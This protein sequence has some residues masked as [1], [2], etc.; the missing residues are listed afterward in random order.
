[1]PTPPKVPVEERLFSLVLALLATEHG[2]TKADILGTVQGYRQRYVHSGDNASLERQFER[3]KDDIRELGVPLETIGEPGQNDNQQLRY[4]IPKAAYEL[5]ADVHFTPEELTLLGLAAQ[6]WREGSLS[7][8][9]RRAILKLGAHEHELDPVLGLAPRLNTRERAFEPLS[10]ALERHV[11]VT[12]PYLKPGAAEARVRRVRPL[13]L[14]QHDG[15]WYLGAHDE[16]AGGDRTFLLSRIS[17]EVTVTAQSFPADDSDHA[18]ATLDDLQRL[19]EQNLALVAVEPGSDAELRLR[20]RA[21]VRDEQLVLHYID[22]NVIADELAAYGPE[23]VVLAPDRLRE[24]VIERM[25]TVIASH[26]SSDNG[27]G[28]REIRHG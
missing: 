15:R 22:T 9:S 20:H 4:R 28:S 12:F 6:V 11:V 2:L 8:D 25:R 7:A 14:V 26:N 18:R 5:P 17:G 23:V 3:D 21:E 19:W 13:S 10:R 27:S 1:M 16:E 24:A